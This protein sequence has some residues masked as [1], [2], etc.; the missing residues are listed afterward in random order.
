MSNAAL[1]IG[2]VLYREW[3]LRAT[4]S[5][6]VDSLS[7]IRFGDLNQLPHESNQLGKIT[8]TL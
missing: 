1:L 8:Y 2:Q 4:K 5:S 3:Y 7:K 6:A